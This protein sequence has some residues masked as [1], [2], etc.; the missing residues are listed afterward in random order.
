VVPGLGV[1]SPTTAFPL[2]RKYYVRCFCRQRREQLFREQLYQLA[3]R[4]AKLNAGFTRMILVP[5]PTDTFDIQSTMSGGSKNFVFSGDLPDEVVG[6]KPFDFVYVV[7]SLGN[8]TLVQL[9]SVVGANTVSRAVW[10]YESAD[11]S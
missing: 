10:S 9:L 4:G 11:L 2:L 5:K 8:A 3:D 1:Q 7:D 6:L